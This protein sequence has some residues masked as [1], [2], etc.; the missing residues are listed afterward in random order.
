MEVDEDMFT[1]VDHCLLCCILL[2]HDKQAWINVLIFG[3][4]CGDNCP[5]RSEWN[6]LW[7]LLSL[8]NELIR[9]KPCCFRKSAHNSR[10]IIC[11][12]RNSI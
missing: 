4:G 6:I 10:Q 12:D 1:C 5:E 8:Q 11:F 3:R 9:L 2:T 7:E